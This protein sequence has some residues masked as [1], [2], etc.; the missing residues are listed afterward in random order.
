M[1]EPVPTPAE[2]DAVPDR[3]LG[4]LR[5]PLRWLAAAQGAWPPHEPAQVRTVSD[6]GDR[7]DDAGLAGGRA[8]GRAEA[9]ALADSGADLVVLSCTG[10]PVPALVA[11]AVLLD[12]DPVHAVGSSGDPATWAHQVVAVRR[13]LLTCRALLAEPAALLDAL[14]APP[15]SRVT[16]LLVQAAA[17]RTPVVLDGSAVAA[18]AA[19]VGERLTPG[20]S[21]WWLAGATPA[22]AAAQE[23]LDALGLVP[24][25]ELGLDLPGTGGL[26]LDLLRWAVARQRELL[27]AGG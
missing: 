26:A 14:D 9:D 4:R 5:E 3:R 27:T 10:D 16:G 1:T 18:A 25:L 23:A 15:L 24:L 6:G 8:G 7:A 13:G 2:V 19:L 17:R 22:G 21:A 12:L 11:C 20:A